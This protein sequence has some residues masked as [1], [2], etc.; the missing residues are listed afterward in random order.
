MKG[1]L[2]SVVPT[3]LNFIHRIVPGTEVLGYC[4]SSLAGLI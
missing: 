1:S 4:Q 3:G 2:L